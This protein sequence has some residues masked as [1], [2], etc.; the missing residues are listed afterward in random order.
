[1]DKSLHYLSVCKDL[2]KEKIIECIESG[3][4]K[5]L[6][7]SDARDLA[8]KTLSVVY[9]LDKDDIPS[10]LNTFELLVEKVFGEYT[11]SMILNNIANEC[12]LY[13]A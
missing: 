4:D 10:S 11:A 7:S 2:A 8:L 1:M 9:G 13:Y 6:G 3:L 12:K 5:S